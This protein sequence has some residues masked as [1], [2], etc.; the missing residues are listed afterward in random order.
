MTS[1]ITAHQITD[2]L[3]RDGE[4]FSCRRWTVCPNVSWG[5]GLAYEAD[6]IAVSKA[7]YVNEVEIKISR[8]DLVADRR[9]AKHTGGGLDPRV[10]RFW[11]AVP[12]VLVEAALSIAPPHHG[13][14]EIHEVKNSWDTAPRLKT[15]ISRAAATIETAK[16]ITTVQ[17]SELLRLGYLRYWDLRHRRREMK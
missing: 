10:K 16:S 5:W 14:I 4:V 9:K 1:D 3:T 15:R 17:M 13:V 12:T 8:S 7:G 11:Y 2:A 6:L